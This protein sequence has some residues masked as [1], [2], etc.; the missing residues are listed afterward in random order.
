MLRQNHN[1]TPDNFLIEKW[2]Q[3]ISV[4]EAQERSL[5]ARNRIV[6][7]LK[8]IMKMPSHSYLTLNI[9]A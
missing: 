6:Q 3:L 4:K 5:W 8:Q 9:A 7:I 2:K 1:N